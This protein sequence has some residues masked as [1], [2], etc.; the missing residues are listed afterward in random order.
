MVFLRQSTFYAKIPIV[1]SANLQASYLNP[2]T[3]HS[4]IAIPEYTGKR[5][6]INQSH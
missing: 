5:Y 2:A 6:P 4:T 3:T 1:M